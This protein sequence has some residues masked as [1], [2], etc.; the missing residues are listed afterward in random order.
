MNQTEMVEISVTQSTIEAYKCLTSSWPY[1][2]RGKF[3]T[4]TS[5]ALSCQTWNT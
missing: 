2:W 1:I 5:V 3:T 4:F